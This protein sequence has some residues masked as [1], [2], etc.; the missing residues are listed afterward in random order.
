MKVFIIDFDGTIADTIPHI[1]NSIKKTIDKFNL[2]KLKYDD[3]LK[4]NGAVLENVLLELGA[5]K[6]QLPEI[7]QYYRNVFSNNIEDI[8]AYPNVVETIKILKKQGNKIIVASNRGKESLNKLLKYLGLSNYLDLVIS[9]SDVVNKKPA[10][11]MI[12]LAKEKLNIKNEEIF[13]IG[14][15]KFDIK[16]GKNAN[17]KT[18]G[19]SYSKQFSIF[20]EQKPNFIITNFKD[21]LDILPDLQTYQMN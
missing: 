12:Y 21:L 9:E 1:V 17:C 19:I 8:K 6:E 11:D 13:I 10:P 20:D 16:M 3:I 7:K 5:Q 14:D 18:I 15:T 4:F 2:K